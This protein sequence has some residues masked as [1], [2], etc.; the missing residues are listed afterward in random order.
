VP[1]QIVKSTKSIC[2][3]FQTVRYFAQN[4]AADQVSGDGSNNISQI[5]TFQTQPDRDREQALI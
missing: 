1:H 4:A 3:N 5:D 2:R